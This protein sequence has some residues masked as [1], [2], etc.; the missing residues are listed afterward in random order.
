ME[1]QETTV[2]KPPIGV[3]PHKLW[4]EDRLEEVRAARQRYIRA[5]VKHPKEW[6]SELRELARYRFQVMK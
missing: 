4:I 3:K 2:V 1:A 6:D 5:K